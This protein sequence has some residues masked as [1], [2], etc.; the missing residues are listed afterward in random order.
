MFSDNDEI[1]L[2]TNNK[3]I[4]KQ[5]SKHLETKKHFKNNPWVKE[6]SRETKKYIEN[7]KE[8]NTMYQNL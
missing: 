3:E 5:I 2:E 7:I 1:K 4:T 8:E 6:V